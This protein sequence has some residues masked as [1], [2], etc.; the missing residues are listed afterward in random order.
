[1]NSPRD[2]QHTDSSPEL[3]NQEEQESTQLETHPPLQFDSLFD[4]VHRTFQS[5]PKQDFELFIAPTTDTAEIRLLFEE[6]QRNLS[7]KKRSSFEGKKLL[8]SDQRS[9]DSAA[10]ATKAAQTAKIVKI[11]EAEREK[12]A[13]KA[14]NLRR[15]MLAVVASTWSDS[16]GKSG[17][18]CQIAT[19]VW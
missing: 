9:L 15:E 19:F 2:A 14:M 4:E 12:K 8:T 16:H 1:M 18:V 10:L 3:D 5:L 7:P 11:K 13:K 17:S 6:V